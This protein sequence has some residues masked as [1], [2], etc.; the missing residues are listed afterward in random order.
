MFGDFKNPANITYTSK[1]K[2]KDYLEY[3]GGL[4]RSAYDELVIIDPDGKSHI[5]KTNLLSFSSNIDIYPGSIIYA[6]RDIGKLSSLSYV[7]AVS[8]VL[9]SLALTLASLN[10]IK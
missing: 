4:K 10:T 2:V 5:Y 9:S 3:A 7:A 6:P 1:L 8:P